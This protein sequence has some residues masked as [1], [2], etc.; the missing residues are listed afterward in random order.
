MP[1]EY[2]RAGDSRGMPRPARRF[3]LLAMVLTSVVLALAALEVALRVVEW[4]RGSAT[5]MPQFVTCGDCPMLY[6]MNPDRPDVSAQGLRGG[7]YAIPKPPGTLRILMLGDSTTYGFRVDAEAT[8]AKRLEAA[9]DGTDGRVEVIN[10]GVNG[11]TPYNELQ[12]FLSEGRAFAAD[13]VIVTFCM[14]DV[15][16]PELH[17]NWDAASRP[18]TYSTNLALTNIPADAIPD[19]AYNRTHAHPQIEARR[20]QAQSLWRKSFLHNFI[21]TRVKRLW[22][23]TGPTD[24]A[25]RLVRITGEDSLSIER[26]LD[27]ASERMLWLKSMYG[28]I[29]EAV[30]RE[31]AAPLA[32]ILPLSYQLDPAYPYLPQQVIAE[33]CRDNGLACLDV[34]PE[35]RRHTGPDLFLGR[36]SGFDDI[37]HLSE[38]GHQ[39]VAEQLAR[40]LVEQGTLPAR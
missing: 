14:N 17:W 33:Q 3:V 18:W 22:P 37:T 34:L 12:Y 7:E 40:F 38:V 26:L 29:A 13:I 4:R 35:F 9:L 20:R 24:A 11:Y 28:Q 32:V 15:A 31:G 21:D 25:G 39:L 16:D 10:A 8:F 36:R 23:P 19:K 5:A 1:M 30:R 6:R 2:T 27:P